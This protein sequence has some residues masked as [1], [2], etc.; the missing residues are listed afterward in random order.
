MPEKIRS[1][2]RTALLGSVALLLLL[3]AFQLGLYISGYDFGAEL[4]FPG[5]LPTVTAV[6]WI[7]VTVGAVLLSLPLPGKISCYEL[8]IPSTLSGD[9]A[10]L[11]IVPMMAISLYLTFATPNSGDGLKSLLA[12]TDPADQTARTMLQLTL[13]AA[14]A[15]AV[16]AF[17]QFQTRKVTPLFATSALLWCGF[18]ALRIYFDMRYLLMSP[19]RVLHLIALIALLVFFVGELRLA[20]GIATHRFYTITATI[21]MILAGTDAL[22]NIILTIIGYIAPGSELATYFIL[23]TVA[24]YCFVRLSVLASD[25]AASGENKKT[26]DKDSPDESPDESPDDS[27]ETVAPLED[28]NTSPDTAEEAPQ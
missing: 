4:Y 2:Q 7:A 28:S 19:R 13:M 15:S 20:R 27:P 21:A 14:V 10:S 6:V 11:L 1:K 22:T 9:Y 16:F 8:K 18:S 23:L 5:H 25:R 17:I 24:I 3:T 26:A 12:S